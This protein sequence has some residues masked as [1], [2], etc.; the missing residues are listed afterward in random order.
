MT[1]CPFLGSYLSVFPAGV[2]RTQKLK[3]SALGNPEPPKIIHIKPVVCMSEYSF[4]CFPC[5]QEV[6]LIL[7]WLKFLLFL[8][9]CLF[10]FLHRNRNCDFINECNFYM[11]ILLNRISASQLNFSL[12]GLLERPTTACCR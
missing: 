11:R 2:P 7:P 10:V 4:P 6:C 8:F 5:C 9:S 12:A 1:V 3:S